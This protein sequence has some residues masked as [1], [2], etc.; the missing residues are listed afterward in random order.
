MNV[1]EEP[2]PA[3]PE[4]G[5]IAMEDEPLDSRP[6]LNVP[7]LK[8]MLAS[9]DDDYDPPHEE[10]KT[11]NKDRGVLP[12][13]PAG[14]AEDLATWMR[15]LIESSGVTALFVSG[16]TVEIERHGRREP[17]A[18]LDGE[19]PVEEAI[20]SWAGR[21]APRPGRDAGILE[22]GLGGG[23]RLTALLSPAAAP[24]HLAVQRTTGGARNLPELVAS[25]ALSREGQE[26][27]EA[28]LAAR[29][30]VVVAGEGLAARLALQAIATALPSGCRAI[31]AAPGVE[32]ESGSSWTALDGAP[33]AEVLATAAALRPDYLVL[34]FSSGI[35][36]AAA[37]RQ[38]A[39]APSATILALSAGSATDALARLRAFAG[40]ALGGGSAG[41]E[42]VAS[43]V[44]LV[45]SAVQLADGSVRFAEIA[46]P[47]LDRE[48][49]LRAEPLVS[50][51]S[52]GIGSE[53]FQTSGSPS[54]LA[55]ALAVRGLAVPASLRR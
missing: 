33:S 30:N 12:P 45:V 35:D 5:D 24:P 25:D 2:P 46:E 17:V 16:T 26:I 42:L 32:P 54:R 23:W 52:D 8:S 43:Y 39:V 22:V 15:S 48:G 10:P 20:R 14:S 18:S 1:F 21:G 53:R 13:P 6:K 9:L 47:R 51:K 3:P 7:P 49:Q 38:A 28:A 27:L 41:R 19:T 55:E 11:A 34:D 31:A 29:R 44:D 50:W 37:F 4:P 40:Q 36:P